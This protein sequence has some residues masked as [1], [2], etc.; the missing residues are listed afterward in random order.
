MFIPTP[1]AIIKFQISSFTTRECL[2]ICDLGYNN[3]SELGLVYSPDT[4]IASETPRLAIPV[5]FTNLTLST[6]VGVLEGWSQSVLVSLECS[7]ILA[8]CSH[9]VNAR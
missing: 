7:S 1:Q 9:L 4:C 2:E 8:C 5:N 6:R 3:P